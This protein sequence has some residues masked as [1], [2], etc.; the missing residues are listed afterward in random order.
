MDTQCG[1]LCG[2]FFSLSLAPTGVSRNQISDTVTVVSFEGWFAF[3]VCEI[4]TLLCGSVP[5]QECSN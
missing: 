5:R 3:S 4:E 2:Y 1:C